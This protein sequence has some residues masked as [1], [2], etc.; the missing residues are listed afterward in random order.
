MT[1]KGRGMFLGPHPL[2][3]PQDPL[4]V[5]IAQWNVVG[6]VEIP[7]ILKDQR[8][9]SYTRKRA[10]TCSWPKFLTAIYLPPANEVCEGYVFT[11]VCLSTWG[12]GMHGF[13]W[14]GGM[15][16]F[17]RGAC[18]VLFGGRAWFYSGGHAWFFQFFRIQWDT[19]NERAVRI[20]LECILVIHEYW[21][22]CLQNLEVRTL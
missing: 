7:L 12:G 15:C 21:D 16:G 3:Q 9:R 8:Y 10:F 19:V 2:T 4:L 6:S 22:F 13:I 5:I 11:G 14:W 18:V 1:A 20:L 17:I